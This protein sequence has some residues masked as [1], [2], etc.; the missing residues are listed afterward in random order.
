MVMENKKIVDQWI[1]LS[2]SLCGGDCF[3]VIEPVKWEYLMNQSHFNNEYTVELTFR[4][5][6]MPIVVVGKSFTDKDHYDAVLDWCY[7]EIVKTMFIT[8]WYYPKIH[9]THQE[10]K[11]SIYKKAMHAIKK[12]FNIPLYN[13][14]K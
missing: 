2:N 4:N 12:I 5:G 6:P 14:D 9:I 1:N 10:A 3:S 13:L 8:M 7:G 11:S